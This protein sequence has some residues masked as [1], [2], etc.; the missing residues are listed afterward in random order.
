MK[1]L[2]CSATTSKA[3]QPPLLP[4]CQADLPPIPGRQKGRCKEEEE[5]EAPLLHTQLLLCLHTDTR[6]SLETS[7]CY[8]DR[9]CQ[10]E[11]VLLLEIENDR[12]KA[13]FLQLHSLSVMGIAINSEAS[14]AQAQ[15]QIS[16][17]GHSTPN[18]CSSNSYFNVVAQQ[19][20]F[21]RHT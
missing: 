11:R 16:E 1:G 6:R 17:V 5:A 10:C 18:T 13:Y 4:G 14:I 3:E 20:L 15:R 7:A 2:T 21:T 9:L 12:N 8:P 19:R